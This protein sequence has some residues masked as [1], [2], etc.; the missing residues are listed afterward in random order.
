MTLQIGPHKLTNQVLLAPMAGVTDWPM[1]EIARRCGAGLCISEMVTAKTR[2][3]ESSKSSTRLPSDL[4]PE[5]RPVQIAGSDPDELARAARL[6]EQM[7]AG[8]IDINMG[9]PAKKVCNRAAGS[10]LLADENLVYRILD[11]VV[12]AVSVPVTLKTRLGTDP[13]NQNIL[14]I[15]TRAEE[16]G[17]QAIS[18][19]GRTR[20]C[21]FNGDADYQL[22]GEV[23][24][25][26]GIPVIANGDINTPEKA[27]LVMQQTGAAAVMVGRGAWGRPW[28][29]GQIADYLEHG[30]YQVPDIGRQKKIVLQHLQLLYQ[31]YDEYRG[32]RFAR[33]HIGWYLEGL[34]PGRKLRSRF[35][36]LE[37]AEAQL[38]LIENHYAALETDK[39]A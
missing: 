24:S 7:G 9:C 31:H 14:S 37:S 12:S 36:Q 29:P 6:C 23:A 26:L 33:K 10:A 17:V 18:I 15:A 4:D 39:A 16:I 22:I 19:H 30:K 1:R 27:A 2:L 34:D 13:D 11:R 38:K 20:A 21:R 3:W 8:I 25:R 32:V 5:P 28:L 35:N